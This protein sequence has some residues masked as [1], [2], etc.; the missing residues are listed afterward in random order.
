MSVLICSASLHRAWK[1]VHGE[2]VKVLAFKK[3]SYS[4]VAS[5]LPS[6]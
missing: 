4:A 1:V 3:M 6:L 2:Y 5:F